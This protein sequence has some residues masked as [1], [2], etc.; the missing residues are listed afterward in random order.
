MLD[1]QSQ[2]NKYELK[3][4]RKWKL[5]AH[6]QKDGG[7]QL[8]SLCAAF[9]IKMTTSAVK[10]RKAPPRAETMSN[11]DCTGQPWTGQPPNTIPTHRGVS[12]SPQGCQVSG[13]KKRWTD[14]LTN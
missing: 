11:R 6:S 7:C 3:I 1:L 12:E 13:S 14:P 9:N 4:L 10:T 8:K 5:K 2:Y